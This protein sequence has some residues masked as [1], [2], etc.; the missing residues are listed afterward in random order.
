MHRQVHAFA[1]AVLL[2]AVALT[3]P[4]SFGAGRATPPAD[5]D[6]FLSR[7]AHQGVTIAARPVPDQDEAEK[8]FGKAAAPIRAGVLPV[9]LLI[10]NERHDGVEVALENIQVMG[11]GQE[12]VQVS[13]EEI[14]L[15]LYPPPGAE[16]PK[17]GPKPSSPI[18]IPRLPVPKDKKDK[19]RAAREGVEAALRSRQWRAREVPP[20]GRARGFLYFALGEEGIDL[21]HASVY[22]PHVSAVASKEGLLFFEIAL[23][24]YAQP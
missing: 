7:D 16:Q 21:A 9:E 6:R 20:G 18:P 1:L 19:K 14:A 23:A 15:A 4:R 5:E 11:E 24:P 10:I 3:P 12:F 2:G 13:P 22:V 8:I 17:V